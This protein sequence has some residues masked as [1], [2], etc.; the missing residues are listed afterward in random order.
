MRRFGLGVALLLSAATTAHATTT[1]DRR[2][3]PG[4]PDANGFTPLVEGPGDPTVAETGLAAAKPGRETR[5]HSL[6]YF[7]Q[8][9]DFQLADEE[10]P[11]RVEVFDQANSAFSAAWRPQEALMPFMVDASI[12]Q[13]NANQASPIPQAKGRR[14]KLA[15]TILTGDNADNQAGVEAQW[16][17]RL[18]DGGPLDPNTGEVTD[19]SMQGSG[20]GA[21]D[22][23]ALAAEAPRYTGVQDYDDYIESG[24]FYDPDMPAAQWAAFPAYPGLLDRAEQPFTATG[25][26]VPSFVALGNHDGLVQGNEAA[27]AELTRRAT[28]CVK[29]ISTAFS[30]DLAGLTESVLTTDPAKTVIVPPDPD[31]APVTKPQYRALFGDQHGFEHI[32]PAEAKASNGAASYYTFSPRT[33]VRFVALD[34]IAN[35]G[36]VGPGSEGNVDDPQFRWLT[37]VLDRAERDDELVLIYS[38]HAPV[39]LSTDLGDEVAGS[40]DDPDHPTNAGCDMDPRTSTP[41]HLEDDLVQLVLAHPHVVGWV[42]GHSHVNDVRLYRS[43]DSQHGFY[44]VRTSAEADFPHQDR[45]LE[46]MDNR[47]G[48]LSLF[49]T[50]LDNAAPATAPPAGDASAF[51]PDQLASVARTLGYNDP[52]ANLDAVGAPEDRNVEL[53]IPDPRA[54]GGT[55]RSVALRARVR[56]RR[57]RAGVRTVLRVRVRS[58]GKPVRRARVRLA[59]KVRRTNR[60]GRARIAVTL[61]KPGRRAV[62]VSKGSRRAVARFRVVA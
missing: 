24:T 30:T 31:R 10:S 2:V 56:P 60:R 21:A 54:K 59:S 62:K 28:G 8:L 17:A 45:L 14:A 16:V 50:L 9:S 58:K 47:D 46:L 22:R 61:R 13:V 33:G 6:L 44:V 4:T 29:T 19:A 23:A 15:L 43:E 55:V 25:L 38:H 3:V 39:S 11:L 37:D 7:A 36:V 53:V 27:V 34:T 12:R 49:G 41:M 52:Q 1:L 18:L 51:T 40:C 35:A 20:C 5:R 42:A 57:V 32:D 26:A 48:T